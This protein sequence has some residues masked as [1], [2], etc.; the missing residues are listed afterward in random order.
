MKK[1]REFIIGESFYSTCSISKNELEQYL[2]FSRIKN[3]LL[4]DNSKE[5]QQLVSGELYYREW[6]GSLQD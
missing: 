6:K 1:F 3:V 2:K 4:D 5:K